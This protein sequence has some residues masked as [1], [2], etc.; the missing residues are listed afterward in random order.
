LRPR[1]APL[2]R[3]AEP[4]HRLGLF[5]SKGIVEA[6]GGRIW[7]ESRVGV[8]TKVRFTIPIAGAAP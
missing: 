5:I 2:Y 4:R 1:G 3:E 8:G 7:I 6:H